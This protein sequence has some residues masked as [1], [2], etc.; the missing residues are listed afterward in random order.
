[1][2]GSLASLY[3]KFIAESNSESILKIG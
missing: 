1:M 3:C 2:V